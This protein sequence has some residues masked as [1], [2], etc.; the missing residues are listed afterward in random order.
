MSFKDG[1]PFERFHVLTKQSYIIK[2]RRMSIGLQKSAENM[3]N[4]VYAVQRAYEELDRSCSGAAISRERQ[5]L[6]SGKAYGEQEGICLLLEK[7]TKAFNARSTGSSPEKQYGRMLV[8]LI[9]D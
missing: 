8:D 4:A 7:T 2:S 3:E 9:R 1:A 5:R 6:E